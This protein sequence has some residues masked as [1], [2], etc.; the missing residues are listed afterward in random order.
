MR[1]YTKFFTPDHV[2][3]YLVSLVNPQTGDV[4]LEPSAGNGAIVRA[5]KQ[6]NAGVKVFSFDINNKYKRLLIDAGAD[7][8][9]IRD[10]ISIPVYAKFTSCISNPPFGNGIDLQAHFDHICSHVKD[11]GHIVMIVPLDFSPNCKKHIIKN[12]TVRPLENWAKNS[13]GTTTEIKILEFKNT[14]Y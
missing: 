9:V 3:K 6:H 8:V 14:N 1:D 4:V 13:D 10:F 7:V 2:A 5:I 12:E 11:G